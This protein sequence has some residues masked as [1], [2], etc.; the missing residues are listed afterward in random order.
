MGCCNHN[1]APAS[2]GF[3]GCL[4]LMKSFLPRGKI[5]T[6]LPEGKINLALMT[7]QTGSSQSREAQGEPGRGCSTPGEGG[8]PAKPTHFKGKIS[9]HGFPNNFQTH[10]PTHGHFSAK[11]LEISGGS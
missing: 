11:V 4:D 10:H 8:I 3:A 7:P 5:E 1:A 6:H 2:V 9:I